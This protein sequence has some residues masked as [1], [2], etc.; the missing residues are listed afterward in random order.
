MSVQIE[1]CGWS[2]PGPSPL[3]SE[4]YTLWRGVKLPQ[5]LRGEVTEIFRILLRERLSVS[6]VISVLPHAFC[7]ISERLRQHLL[8]EEP[9]DSWPQ[10][11]AL[12]LSGAAFAVFS[13]QKGACRQVYA[14]SEH[15]PGGVPALH[16]EAG[17]GLIESTLDCG[18]QMFGRVYASHSRDVDV[19]VHNSNVIQAC[20][21]IPFDS[22]SRVRSADD[23]CSRS[24]TVSAYRKNLMSLHR[25]HI[26]MQ[27]SA[28]KDVE[29]CPIGGAPRAIGNQY[30]IADPN[31]YEETR[32]GLKRPTIAE[33]VEGPL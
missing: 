12:M 17:R 8:V 31:N 26:T 20:I 11:S 18:G 14:F 23:E 28:T 7:K 1:L 19:P 16:G 21:V 25:K 9:L 27:R 2:T 24:A 32:L 33:S 30:H 5:K 22:T 3:F 4:S 6:T 15:E 13:G 10:F 29:C